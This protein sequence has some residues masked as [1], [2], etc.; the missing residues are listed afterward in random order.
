M[1]TRPVFGLLIS[2][3]VPMMISM[4]VN[5]LYNIVD[6]IYI[7]SL[8]TEA[9]TALSLIFP[10]Q[11]LVIAA[12]VGLGVGANAVIAKNLG[13]KDQ[14]MADTAAVNGLEIAL[15]IAFIYMLI[16]IFG[17]KPFVSLFTDNPQITSYAVNYGTIVMTFSFGNI[18][19]VYMEKVYQSVG[20]MKITMCFL[21]A[22]A[23]IN[24]I[25]DPILIFGL[26]GAPALGTAGA[27]IA[28]VFAQIVVFTFYP[29]ASHFHPIP[30]HF[31]RE[32]MAFNGKL[33][34]QI[35]KVALP[36]GLTVGLPSFLTSV[37]NSILITYSEVYVAVLGI[38][39]KIQ[40]FFYLPASGLI[41]GMRP[42]VS[43]NY[44][45]GEYSRVRKTIRYA[46]MIIAVIMGVG[47]VIMELWPNVI[48]NMFQAAPDLMDAGSR[49]FRIIAIGFVPSSIGLT[50]CGAFEALGKGWHSL[51]V[52]TSRQFIVCV[53]FSYLMVGVM[54]PDAVWLSFPIA[55]T[56][57][58]LVAL[59]LLKRVY[60]R[61]KI[62]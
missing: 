49:A 52:S 51:A 1:K 15:I 39:F 3:G 18:L 9:L 29:I 32:N 38:Y 25:L 43:Y 28:T 7:A 22:A 6:S 47:T 30:V 23:G 16:G 2:M 26:L 17:V 5:S 35:L 41:Q 45:A 46:M 24:A 19:Q 12:G 34:G 31:K 54:G 61:E 20:R 21:L 48:L 27:A 62:V 10:M 8:G 40:T 53:I 56:V 36:S 37:L 14:K 58:A 50:A 33:C 60:R 11:N 42:I 55:E 4:L 44:G 59:M 13:A 57:A